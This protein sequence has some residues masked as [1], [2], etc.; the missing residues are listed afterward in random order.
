MSLGC[1]FNKPKPVTV[2]SSEQTPVVQEPVGQAWLTS[3]KIAIKASHF[4]TAYNSILQAQQ[5]GTPFSFIQ[6][7]KLTKALGEPLR[8]L[9]EISHSIQ[10]V[11]PFPRF[12]PKGKLTLEAKL[13]AKVCCI[14]GYI[15][16]SRDALVGLV[17][18]STV[19]E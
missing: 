10:N 3:S 12:D 6:G 13:M 19:D 8:A 16:I 18:A 9:Q 4:Q 5:N 11:P 2:R 15:P 1:T 17:I 14:K 7:C